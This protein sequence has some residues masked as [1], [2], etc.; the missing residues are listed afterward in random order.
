MQALISQSIY[1]KRCLERQEGNKEH[2]Q[3]RQ[4]AREH[5]RNQQQKQH[6]QRD[7]ERQRETGRR[8][9]P[10]RT[11]REALSEEHRSHRASFTESLR[12][13]G[14]RYRVPTAVVGLRELSAA[15]HPREAYLRQR[16]AEVP[17][18]PM[19][20]SAIN[21]LR[22]IKAEQLIAFLPCWILY[23]SLI[24]SFTI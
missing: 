24:S 19:P 4:R 16:T 1:F 9:T 2:Q 7:T 10:R 8:R 14:Y 22:C 6:R 13:A 20:V 12:A 3:Q 17:A 18:E 5:S 15:V 21:K 23:Y 11:D